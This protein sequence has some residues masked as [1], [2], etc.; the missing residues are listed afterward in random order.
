MR[1]LTATQRTALNARRIRACYL[2]EIHFATGVLR[3]TTTP[4]TVIRNGYEWLGFGKLAG[5]E[6]PEET[7]ELRA[8]RARITINGLDAAA[9][10]LALNE[11]TENVPLWVH[12]AL[13]D[14]DTNAQ[15]GTFVVHR[16]TI[17]DV[18]IVP[19]TSQGSRS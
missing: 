5:V 8:S 16:G 14:P 17:G 2:V 1:W 19:A 6:F 13:M 3:Y 7:A 15:L 4:Y 9:I 12:L 11:R 18:E 10:S